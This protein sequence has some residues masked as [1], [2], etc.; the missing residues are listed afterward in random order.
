MKKILLSTA[1]LAGVV[2]AY[3]GGF[4]VSLQ[5]VKQ[6]AM[7]HTSA[8]A[9]DAS[10][11]FFNPAGMSFVPHKLSIV[12]GGFGIKSKVEYQNTN[13]NTSEFTDNPMG[14]PIYA[15][16][17]YKVTDRFA[18]GFNFSTPY[19]S[20]VKYDDNWTGRELV[21]R[22]E[23]KGMFFQPMVSVKVTDWMS[24]G[25][26]YIYAKGLVNWDKAATSL[27]G[28]VNIKDDKAKGHGFGLGVY[29]R[30]TDRWD[31]SASYRSKVEMKAENGV[32]TFNN[33]SPTML[34]AIGVT[35][36]TN[37]D[38]F[39]AVLPLVAEFTFGTS[40]KVTPAWKVAY[41]LNIQGWSE[42]RELTLDFDKAM[43]GNQTDR[44]ILAT[45]KNFTGSRV[46]R[47]GTQYQFNNR[48]AGRLGYY[49]DQKVYDDNWFTPETPSFNIHGFTGGFGFNFGKFGLDLAAAYSYSDHRVFRNVATNFGGQARAKAF[50]FGLGLSYNA[51]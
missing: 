25:A 34:N 5:G 31:V 15:A 50:T 39:T 9:D 29:M 48:I 27:G 37:Q 22:M 2:S 36:G 35:G 43:I 40:Y 14:T 3:A 30:P 26:S 19:G 4:R 17:S 41:D 21:Q 33:V 49:M 12:A 23:L 46:H 24:L 20:T 45:P 10:V 38:K 11:T 44:T 1:L 28:T 13:T 8:H 18:L 32:I 16:V 42:Y 6:F 7:A 51:F 47:F